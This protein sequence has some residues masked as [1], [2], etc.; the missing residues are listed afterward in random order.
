L[1]IDQRKILCINLSRRRKGNVS[2]N[3]VGCPYCFHRV[4]HSICSLPGVVLTRKLPNPRRH[5]VE[6]WVPPS[7]HPARLGWPPTLSLEAKGNIRLGLR[8]IWRRSIF[9][10]S[11]KAPSATTWLGRSGWG[12]GVVREGASEFVSDWKDR[13]DDVGPEFGCVRSKATAD[14]PF[15]LN[16]SI[17]SVRANLY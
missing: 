14:L 7:R 5:S 6:V 4:P 2:R 15:Q 1:W 16:T 13:V 12:G 17:L 3:E 9:K 11:T 8:G 10:C